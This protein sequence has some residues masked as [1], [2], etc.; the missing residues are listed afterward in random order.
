MIRAVSHLALAD[1]SQNA[2]TDPYVLLVVLL[3]LVVN[4]IPS[5]TIRLYRTIVGKTTIQQ[6]R[7]AWGW[8]G[9]GSASCQHPCLGLAKALLVMG[10]VRFPREPTAWAVAVGRHPSL[11]VPLSW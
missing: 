10:R 7:A 3:S 5:L 8:H 1:A 4:T 9:E 2:L 11:E 6:V